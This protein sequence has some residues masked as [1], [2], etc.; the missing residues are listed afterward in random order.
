MVWIMG[1]PHRIDV[2]SLHADHVRQ[3]GFPGDG[4][5]ELRAELMPVGPLEHNALVVEHHQPILQFKGA[6][7]AAG[8]QDRFPLSVHQG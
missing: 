5:T 4:T 3:H 2:V 7:S 1:S 6:E 8:R